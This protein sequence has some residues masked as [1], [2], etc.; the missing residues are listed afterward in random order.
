MNWHSCKRGFSLRDK[1][2]IGLYSVIRHRPGIWSLLA[3]VVGRGDWHLRLCTPRGA[4]RLVFNPLDPVELTVVDELLFGELYVAR[5]S[6][7]VLVDCGAFR[8]ISTIYLQDQLGAETVIA[9][10][11][12][13]DNFVVLQRRLQELSGAVQCKNCAVG[14]ED[15][16]VFFSGKGIGGA[17]GK[18]GSSIGQVRLA[19][20][21]KIIR[22]GSLLLKMDVEGAEEVIL[23]DIL[24]FLPQRCVIWLETH[25]G[26]D[27]ARELLAPYRA[28]GFE[29]SMMRSRPDLASDAVFID[30]KLQ[31]NSDGAD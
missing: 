15:K 23:P 31:R 16:Q 9:F 14:D 13:R 6:A 29:V 7:D 22:A 10:E 3:K 18:E 2:A 26:E 20:I 1:L 24:P 21:E 27:R 30:W 17:V 8:G 5:R 25:F 12:Q 4:A 28:A 11:P 19:N